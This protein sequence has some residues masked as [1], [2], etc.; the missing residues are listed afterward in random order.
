MIEMLFYLL[1]H[2]YC[3]LSMHHAQTREYENLTP[4]PLIPR[5]YPDPLLRPITHEGYALDVGIPSARIRLGCGQH[6]STLNNNGSL[7][8]VLLIVPV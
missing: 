2:D 4:P 8:N 6:F 1:D 3:N 5:R 7:V